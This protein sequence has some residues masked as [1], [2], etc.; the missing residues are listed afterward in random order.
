MLPHSVLHTQV[1]VSLVYELAQATRSRELKELL[2][3]DTL[4]VGSALNILMFLWSKL[5]H[6][7]FNCLECEFFMDLLSPPPFNSLP[8]WHK[9]NCTVLL[10]FVCVRVLRGSCLTDEMHLKEPMIVNEN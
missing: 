10:F 2:P 7:M 4:Y 6:C 5:N 3:A 8:P 9:T 1:S